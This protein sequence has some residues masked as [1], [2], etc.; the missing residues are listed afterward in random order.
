MFFTEKK[1]AGLLN[2]PVFVFF[3]ENEATA[4]C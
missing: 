1:L 3:S 4:S 2:L